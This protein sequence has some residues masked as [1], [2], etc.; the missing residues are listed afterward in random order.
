MNTP[1]P[2]LLCALAGVLLCQCSSGSKKKPAKKKDVASMSLAQR[3]L[4]KPDE[5]Q[6]SQYEKYISDSKNGKGG[7]GNYFQ[8]QVHHSKNFSG[9]N[10]Y[11]GGKEFK[12]SQ[13]WFGKSKAQGTDMTYSLGNRQSQA[14]KDQF[15]TSESTLG[16]QRARE[17]T[18]TFSGASNVFPTGNALTR[19]AGAPRPPKIIEN[20]NDQAG[21]KKSAYSEDEVRRLINRN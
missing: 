17:G 13:S 14:S 5:N 10:S 21:G 7:A 15:K 19:S 3:S 6:R 9:G 11:A 18:S 12:T 16:S 8:K 2:L 4:L 20:Y 1:L